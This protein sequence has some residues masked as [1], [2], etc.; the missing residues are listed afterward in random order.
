M[1]KFNRI[2]FLT[3]SAILLFGIGVFLYF[4]SG[5]TQSEPENSAAENK[6][7]AESDRSL[8]WSQSLISDLDF[9]A[10]SG[11]QPNSSIW[12]EN[13]NLVSQIQELFNPAVHTTSTELTI[14]L[15]PGDLQ[16][17]NFQKSAPPNDYTPGLSG[18]SEQ[19][20]FNSEL[21]ETKTPNW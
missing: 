1:S 20:A 17:N 6:S 15:T 2:T 3:G 7:T 10:F 8:V 21:Q 12:A 11:L 13:W 4:I 9:Q 14:F 19:T 18:Q 16:E 5:P